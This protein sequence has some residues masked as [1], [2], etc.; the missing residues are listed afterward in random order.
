MTEEPQNVLVMFCDQLRADLPGYAGGPVRT[1][2]LDALAGDALVFDNAY[3]PTAICS[4]ARASLMT[5][6]YPHG[7]HMYNNSTPRYSY[8]H[9]LPPEVTMLQD[10]IDSH[11]NCRTGY[12]GKWHIG[13]SGDLFKSTFHRTHPRAGL[14]GGGPLFAAGHGHP[15][16]KLGEVVETRGNPRMP[17]GQRTG[18]LDVPMRDFPDVQAA[19]YTREFIQ[20]RD[21]QTPFCAVC[22]FPGPHSPWLIPHEFGVRYVPEDIALWQNRDDPLNGKPLNQQK[23]QRIADARAGNPDAAVRDENMRQKLAVCFSYVE[24]ID[25]CVGEVIRDLKAAGLYEQTAIIFTADHGDMAGA[26][27][28]HSKG[29][30]MYDEIYRIPMLY[31][32]AGRTIPGRITEPVHLMDV[33]ATC[34]DV[35]G[36]GERAD[37]NGQPLHGMSL[38]RLTRDDPDW[39]RSVHYAEYHGDWYGHYSAR[40]VTDG[41]WKLVWNFSDLCELYDTAEDPNELNNRFYDPDCREIR[42]QL[43]AQLHEPAERYEDGQALKFLREIDDIGDFEDAIGGQYHA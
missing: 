27:G 6:L 34:V 7:H 43:F 3:T 20:E 23:L 15:N 11:T 25:E 1:P 17:L 32:P 30:Y 21:S 14:E 38:N 18:T 42:S 16:T 33:T 41:R 8:C 39:P 29:S 37:M 10:W 5:G 36:G 4:P 40:M 22:S 26:H 31:K 2:N 9:H 13:P 19:R 12:F 28:F 24:L 35:L